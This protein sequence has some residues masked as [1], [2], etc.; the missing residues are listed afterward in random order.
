MG[1]KKFFKKLG[2]NMLAGLVGAGVGVVVAVFYVLLFWV[3]G[4]VEKVGL[5]IVVILPVM[6]ILFSIL[7]VIVG[8]ILGIIG[9]WI[10]KVLKKRKKSKVLAKGLVKKG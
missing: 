9:Y 10:L 5:G 1:S 8:G 2:K 6:I 7:G 4:N 3:P